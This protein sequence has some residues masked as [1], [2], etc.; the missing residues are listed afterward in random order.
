MSFG[1]LRWAYVG[2]NRCHICF[3]RYHRDKIGSKSDGMGINFT[4]VNVLRVVSCVCNRY[5]ATWSA[6]WSVVGNHI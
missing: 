4:R 2:L 1:W 3:V 6:S 5:I